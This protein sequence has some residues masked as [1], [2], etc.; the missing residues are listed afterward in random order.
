MNRNTT[1]PAACRPAA[2][3]NP[4]M[5]LPANA[6]RF[7][8]RRK[9][10]LIPVAILS[11]LLPLAS[12]AQMMPPTLTSSLTAT[13]TVDAPFSYTLTAVG[14][15]PITYSVS[16][17][18]SG[19]SYS[20]GPPPMIT[21]AP[22]ALEITATLTAVN[23]SGTDIQTLVITNTTY[24]PVFTS[25]L[26]VTATEGFPFNYTMEA[27]GDQ[28]MEYFLDVAAYE[29]GT[30]SLFITTDITSGTSVRVATIG[31]AAPGS[32]L[33][34]GTSMIEGTGTLSMTATNAAGLHTVN[35]VVTGTSLRPVFTSP[36]WLGVQ[37]GHTGTYQIA[38]TNS[39]TLYEAYKYDLSGTGNML[40]PL[41][42]GISF[43]T[44]TGVLTAS[45]T[46]E[47]VA[48]ILFVASNPYGVRTMRFKVSGY[49]PAPA[50][51]L[52]WTGAAGVDGVAAWNTTD[53]NWSKSGAAQAFT[54]G[55]DVL[56]DDSS[57]TGTIAITGTHKPASIT[58]RN[59]GHTVTIYA[60]GAENT[61][62]GTTPLTMKGSGTLIIGGS[63]TAAATSGWNGTA[64]LESGVFVRQN[65][66]LTGPVVFAG[67]TLGVTYTD[68]SV[69]LS[70]IMSVPEGVLGV[71]NLPNRPTMG[72]VL[73][74]SGTLKL[75]YRSTVERVDL[76]F[77]KDPSN[78]NHVFFGEVW[79]SGTGGARWPNAQTGE[80]D[81]LRYATLRVDCS[82]ED[83]HA[84]VFPTA[85][86]SG[87]TT[88]YV[89]ALSGDSPN[90]SFM[91]GAN[92]AG[93][94]YLRI[95]EK[96]IDSTFAG[97][98][99]DFRDAAASGNWKTKTAVLKYGTG[100]LTFTGSHNY[101]LGT[102]VAAGAL[103]LAETASLL[104][105]SGVSVSGNT[106]AFG[107]SGLVRPDVTFADNTTLLVDADPESGELAGLYVNGLVTFSGTTGML[108]VRPVV[109][110]GI[111]TN[112]VYTALYSDV[113]F[114]GQPTLEWDY[115][116]DAG[117]KAEF[118]YIKANE[119]QVTITGGA[120]PKPKIT[121]GLRADAMAG[122]PFTYTFTALGDA[123]APTVFTV[124]D[125]P[126]G[127]TFDATTGIIAGTVAVA[128]DYETGLSAF[129]VTGTNTATLI[130][131]VYDTA[132][133]A[134]D[135]TS[136][137]DF[138]AIVGRPTHY[139][140]EAT[141][142]PTTFTATDLPHGLS[143]DANG[144]ITGKSELLGDYNVTITAGNITG[145][146]T[147]TLLLRVALP[148]PVVKVDQ[149]SIAV[150]NT[151]YTREISADNEPTGY[152]IAGMF[153][154]VNNSVTTNP[155]F[156]LTVDG[157]TG[158]ISG[159]CP[160]VET[161]GT[162]AFAV[163]GTIFAWNHTGTGWA[164]FRVT[165]NPQAPAMLDSGNY[166]GV[167]GVPFL[168]NIRA[169][170]MYPAYARNYG[171][172]NMPPG[173]NVNPK[174]G[175]ITGM[176]LISGVFES[177]LVASNVTAS[178]AQLI[179]F[180]I[181]GASIISTLAGKSG[182]PGSADGPA[183]D[184]RFNT[185]G[186]VF[187][188][189]D[190]NL[191]I[192]DTGNNA[193]R[194]IDADG[195]VS[196]I[197]TTGLNH[198]SAIVM[199]AAG[200]ALYVADTAGNAIK[201]IDPATGAVSTLALTGDP[202]LSAPHGLAP[203]EA[204]NLYVADT[205]NNLIRKITLATGA[206]TTL[207]GSAQ[208]S[209]D[210][211][212]AAAGFDMPT[213]LAITPDGVTLCVA[214]TG[215]STIRAIATANGAVST[216]AGSAGAAG[217]TDETGAAARFNTPEGLAFDASGVLYVADTGN[218]CIRS[219]DTTTGK[220]ITLAGASGMAGG[221]DGNVTQ[222]TMNMPCGITIGPDGQVYVA[223]TDN[224]TIRTLQ[225]GPAIIT[226]PAD[227][228]VPLNSPVTFRVVAS[229]APKPT[230]QWYKD[231][232]I[233]ADATEPAFALDNIQLPDSAI[234]KVIVTNPLGTRT[235]SAFLTLSD[236][237]PNKPEDAGVTGGGDG[238]GGGGGAPSLW[239]LS[240]LALIAALY[241]FRR[242]GSALSRSVLRPPSSVLCPLSSVLCLL[243]SVLC[244]PPSD[245]AAQ[246]VARGTITGRVLN[247]ATGQ[248]LSNAVVTIEGTN[249][250]T[251]TDS[252]GSYRLIDVPT[253][254]VRVAASYTG[255]DRITKDVTVSPSAAATA[256]FDMTAQIYHMETFSVSSAREG[257]ARAIQEQ[258]V[259][260]SQKAIFAADSFGNIV[261]NN[262]GELMKNLPGI[263][264]DYEGED[265]A[266]MRIRGM[267]PE[268]ATI[269]LD[270]N[271]VASVGVVSET[272]DESRA[273]NLKTAA[274]QN[275][276][277]IELKIAP[278]PED[279]A[280]TMGGTIDI[281]TKSALSQKGRRLYFI[282]N[283]SLNTAELD[284]SK[285]PGGGRTPNRKIQPGFNVGWSET[286][287]GKQRFGFAFDMGF[288]RN[289]RYNN[290]YELPNGYTYDSTFLSEHDNKLTPDTP[291]YVN[292]LRWTERGGSEE[293]RV[294]SLNLD[295]QPWG[296]N[297]SFFVRSSYNDTRGLGIYSRSMTLTAGNRADGSDL[298]TL[299]SPIG[300]RINMSNSVSAANNRNY[301]ISAGGKHKFSRLSVDYNANY[302]H[303]GNDPDPNENF[304]IG[305][306]ATGLGLNVFNIAGNAV[307]RI[308][309]T[310][311]DSHSIITATDPR[312]YQN[313][314][315]YNSLTYSHNFAHGTDERL[316]ARINIALPVVFRVPFTTHTISV[317]IKAGASYGEQSRHT[318]RYQRSR[319]LTGG[320]TLPNFLTPAEPSLMQ[321]I[322][323]YFRNS[324]GFDVP[325][326]DWV[327]PYQI[328]DY[329]NTHPDAF[330][331]TTNNDW[332]GDLYNELRNER[333]T[334]EATT[335]GY[336]M[337]TARLLRSLT[338]I[339]GL[340]YER[341]VN[342]GA[343]P[344]YESY[345]DENNHNKFNET[346]K[347]DSVTA[348]LP[349][350]DL[351]DPGNPIITYV[352]NPR[353]GMTQEEKI[354]YL[355]TRVA[356]KNPAVTRTFPNIQLKWTPH[357][358]VNI[359][360]ARTENI[361]RPKF[362]NVLVQE[363]WD[364]TSR[365]VSRTNPSV[366]PSSSEKYDVS[367]EYYPGKDAMLT[368][369]LFY[370]KFKDIIETNTTFLTVTDNPDEADGIDIVYD[371][372][373]EKGLWAIQTPYNIGKGQNEGFE[374][375]YRQKLGFIHP[376][377][378][379]LEVYGAFSYA[380]P[381]TEYQRRTMVAPSKV[382]QETMLEYLTS[383]LIWETIPMTG[384]QK[385]SA[386]LQLR[387]NGRKWSGKIAGYWVDE[388]ARSI[389]KDIVEVNNQNAYIRFDFSFTYKISSR[390]TASFDWR[391]M[392]NVGD[393]RKIFDRT[394]GY[395]TSGMVMNFGVKANF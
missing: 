315:N 307:A 42:S 290:R 201:K 158:L 165:V 19:L 97:T 84:W 285:T 283:L 162:V 10:G 93:A 312:S 142:F 250:E 78:G 156:Y 141:N 126:E 49:E 64:R 16:G 331:N 104:G 246:Q 35:L 364:T 146:D 112:G 321:F 338:L 4:A 374:L 341:L 252:T 107:G 266:S 344:S 337:F 2:T 323:P 357:K 369:S 86:Y 151:L 278:T 68:A 7:A 174:T 3:L 21:G 195:T 178:G 116:E 150:Q 367:V 159:T 118:S 41:P 202:A 188:D 127:L 302:S 206:M 48:D 239:Y 296:P 11:C 95:G 352:P 208:G 24:R 277:S 171:V 132:P 98:I 87:N 298:Y 27:V 110:G 329:H 392:T 235:V 270:G 395:F 370:Q 6:H 377:L 160:N 319:R 295:Y 186:A 238:G 272:G 242:R 391:N 280:S 382:N 248:Y 308:V 106:A 100:M 353:L 15:T 170:N 180:T 108:K 287:G 197:A 320:S 240:A 182:I 34:T 73:A 204:G 228:S 217:N 105:A 304:S 194:K 12:G 356:F 153:E 181:N 334:K 267:D 384:I 71:I 310:A 94:L 31:Q 214:D 333:E 389:K 378:A 330:Y 5:R 229:G 46:S 221:T 259:S 226:P 380:N 38:A 185:P 288:T 211:T 297:H 279:P 99:G 173:L 361:G 299:L 81:S 223:D 88:L 326:A 60:A 59:S 209:A 77:R 257:S 327:N 199:D 306:G 54:D 179:T 133:A 164:P 245:L 336:V 227:Q 316:G 203:D 53:V 124:A 90:V 13:G 148:P 354:R 309:Q 163:S 183:A 273:F 300:A 340:R 137:L 43:N 39:P 44:T 61:I 189:K 355:F 20:G 134:P 249:F 119:L 136:S 366:K 256:D 114:N 166:A 96:N 130:L 262:I 375:T 75:N 348:T 196:T 125:M 276:E 335:A 190:G 200:T 17:L 111:I 393:D 168:H 47:G 149:G 383:P 40:E 274:L 322:D 305:Y 225:V 216:L 18:S 161:T 175:Q 8:T 232:M 373:H 70:Q 177:A 351:S 152:A 65:Q 198:P 311:H 342:S 213:G 85:T 212:G 72:G 345:L 83:G 261:D 358:D 115:P 92:N 385:R 113:A 62:T 332:T 291:G 371:D 74:G 349:V 131:R 284:F 292:Q 82:T 231:D 251:L 207:A 219:I 57:T 36:G 63:S 210:G 313:L 91:G 122:Q 29:E 282:A 143:I 58:A 80:W 1:L 147:K 172:T 328:Q 388:F 67:G 253:G 140:I 22:T 52:L 269:T 191:Y 234:Y 381:E 135:I 129:N 69:S 359:R 9:R 289:Y 79:L 14:D 360:F 293:K 215:N 176:P 55:T 387:Y 286:F 32:P 243:S 362:G 154:V 372:L 301:S 365:I 76:G 28:P 193:I 394:G 33:I 347:Y 26:A 121:S 255:L 184:A 339:A 258:R 294:V 169:T 120:I 89:G 117:V 324:W 45:P 102:T 155:A 386:N 123:S 275:I 128:G 187:S 66:G 224:H 205:G 103:R 317:E 303:A 376:S 101:R 390:W 218:H 343:G 145:T 368:L 30:N 51:A 50:S 230:Y 138:G 192:A 25:T 139:Q 265:A 318:Y 244:L 157:T 109:P 236:V 346:Y 268:M 37:V 56:F 167:V 379:P 222:S 350:V 241:R 144:L 325:I 254:P 260:A 263:T 271:E 264:I 247:K 281:K 314:E 363:S 233:I 220:V 237:T 23:A